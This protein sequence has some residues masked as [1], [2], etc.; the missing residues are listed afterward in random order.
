M[1]CW[2]STLCKICNLPFSSNLLIMKKI[3]YSDTHRGWEGAKE[4][5]KTSPSRIAN[6]ALSSAVS[7]SNT[8]I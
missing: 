6:L 4:I 3:Y 8:T 5:C 2:S 7:T 1:V